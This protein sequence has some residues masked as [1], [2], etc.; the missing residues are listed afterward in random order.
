MKIRHLNPLLP[1]GLMFGALTSAACST[2]PLAYESIESDSEAIFGGYTDP[3]SLE[4]NVVVHVGNCT[5]TL[6]TPQIV[7]SAAH[8]GEPSNVYFGNDAA[9]VFQ[10]PI[11]VTRSVAHPE[12][13][14]GEP[15][16][17]HPAGYDARLV[18]LEKPVAGKAKVR[19]P[20]LRAPLDVNDPNDGDFGMAGWSTCGP[21]ITVPDPN[22]TTRQA[23]NFHLNEFYGPS[24]LDLFNLQNVPDGGGHLWYRESRLTGV[25]F[26]DSGGPLYRTRSDGTRDPIGVTAL[27]YF[28]G[29]YSAVAAAWT[30]VTQGPVKSWLLANVA[31]S[32]NGGHSAAWLAAHGKAA[33]NF[34][35]GEADYSGVCDTALDPDCD[36]WYSVHDNQPTV[37][38]PL[39]EEAPGGACASLCSNPTRSSNR[40]YHSGNMGSQATCHE[41]SANLSGMVCGNLASGRRLKVNGKTIDCSRHITLPAK[42]N[43]GYCVQTNAGPYDWAYF[44]TW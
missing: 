5:G 32:A 36:Y 12:Y 33:D 2:E 38:N 42:R 22:I 17:P 13:H 21:N 4:A 35:F 27:V 9:T 43:G 25:C 24:G 31:D 18:F 37:F 15:D 8:C 26:G 7:L 6:I 3:N 11:R 14:Y 1:T 30:D 28:T 19:R 41:L 44:A 16:Q 23:V 39:Q 34:W 40:Y 29:D 20:S 10:D